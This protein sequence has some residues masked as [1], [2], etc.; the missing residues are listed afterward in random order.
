MKYSTRPAQSSDYEFLFELKR[1]LNLS[2]SKLFLA[3]MSKFNEIYTPKSGQKK[4]LKSLN[5][6]AKRLA[7]Y[8]CKTKV[9][10]STFAD[11]S[12]C[13]NIM[14]RALVAK[15]SPIA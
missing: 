4:G 2:Q 3:G 8:C 11:S 9:T 12:C 5:I 13:L 1:R 10:T 14:A 15:S 7:V 6:R